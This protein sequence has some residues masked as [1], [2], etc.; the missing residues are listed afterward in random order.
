MP[1][2]SEDTEIIHI[3]AGIYPKKLPGLGSC[4]GAFATVAEGKLPI[5]YSHELLWLTDHVRELLGDINNY[6]RLNIF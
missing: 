1:Q 3:M 5:V 4:G 2:S 6:N